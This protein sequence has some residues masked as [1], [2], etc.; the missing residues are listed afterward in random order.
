MV[1]RDLSAASDFGVL[2]TSKPFLPFGP[3]PEAGAT[4]TL[5]S[6]EIFSKP[7][8]SIAVHVEW[9]KR[10]GLMEYFRHLPRSDYT[11]GAA[12]LVHGE[13]Q[14]M[15]QSR[16]LF[17]RDGDALRA[18]MRPQAKHRQAYQQAQQNILEDLERGNKLTTAD[19]EK[20][21]QRSVKDSDADWLYLLAN[22]DRTLTYSLEVANPAEF[23]G[24]DNPVYSNKT[25]NGF[26]RLTLD[27]G[28]G[29]DAFPQIRTLALIEAAKESSG[30][31]LDRSGYNVDQLSQQ[32]LEPYLP[33]V[34][35]LDVDYTCVQSPVQQTFELNPFGWCEGATGLLP[36]IDFAG[37]LF[38]GIADFKVPANVSLL[39]RCEEGSSN[40]LKNPTQL[41]VSVLVDDS[42][43]DV[44]EDKISDTSYCLSTT[45]IV[46]IPVPREAN[47]AH[48]ILDYGLTWIRIAV[49]RDTDA[50]AQLIDILPNAVSASRVISPDN[51]NFP[52][53]PLPQNTLS[54]FVPAIADVKEAVQPDPSFAGRPTETVDTYTQRVA[55]RLRHKGRAVTMWDYEHLVLEQFPEVYKVK[56]LNHTQLL[57]DGDSNI[58][59]DNELKPGHVV[60]VPLPYLSATSDQRRPYARKETLAQISSFL[61]ERASP[62]VNIEVQNA[63]IEEVQLQFAVALQ[64]H[65]QGDSAFY[66]QELNT[67]LVMYLTPWMH[68][69]GREVEFGGRWHKSAA[70]AF[71]ESREYVDYIKDVLMF[72][73][74]DIDGDNAA[75]TS[76]LDL[77]SASTGRSILVSHQQHMITDALA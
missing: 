58:T 3:C 45:G 30:N 43:V 10:Y 7:L 56:C 25:R 59:A 65:A 38:I 72:H 60:I 19:Q 26:L 5:G 52:Q 2:D 62:F 67:Q 70:I 4:F 36:N 47:Q 35:A 20:E 29:F 27:E 24:P 13:W 21:I 75:H 66:R 61:T 15:D 22:K 54:K 33:N 73:H 53:T 57:R 74:T 32:P 12:T 48:N 6:S 18:V 51:P 17:Y 8:E 71:I 76:N 50:V 9:E 34:V 41:H 68:Q 14:D 49:E 31:L 69:E 16:T 77:V 23:S 37:Q 11:V 28:F 44:D 1:F 39:F 64:P 40:P 46:T 63:K 55:E 42:W